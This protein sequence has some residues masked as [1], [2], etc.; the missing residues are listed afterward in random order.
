MFVRGSDR[1]IS[2]ERDDCDDAEKDQCS[3][4]AGLTALN[5]RP[6][7]IRMFHPSSAGTFCCCC[8]MPVRG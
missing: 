1:E 2:D 5:A 3:D 6:M 8:V 7:L 4:Y